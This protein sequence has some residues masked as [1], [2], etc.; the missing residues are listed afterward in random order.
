MMGNS[1]LVPN[2]P[3][4]KIR[5][6]YI[7]GEDSSQILLRRSKYQDPLLLTKELTGLVAGIDLSRRRGGDICLKHVDYAPYI[8][9]ENKRVKFVFDNSIY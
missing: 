1:C 7:C 4:S 9:L 8:F 6:E 5:N 2:P 3:V